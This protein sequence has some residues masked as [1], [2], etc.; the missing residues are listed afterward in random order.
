MHISLN[1]VFLKSLKKP[2]KIIRLSS[3]GVCLLKLIAYKGS[4][5]LNKFYWT[6]YVQQNA[7]L[8]L[9]MI[10]SDLN[11]TSIYV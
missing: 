4:P 7:I 11:Y 10:H 2:D 8:L 3:Q 5:Q 9:K 1:E 6:P